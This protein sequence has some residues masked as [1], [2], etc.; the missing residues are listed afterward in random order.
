MINPYHH[1]ILE[2]IKESSG[3][4]T[5][6]TLLDTYL[7]NSHPR[8]PITAPVLRTIAK[9][10]MREH[11]DLPKGDFRAMLTSLINGVSSTEKSNGRDTHGLC[12]AIPGQFSPENF[13]FMA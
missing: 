3:K 9:S 13:Q 8:Y 1:D 4:G 5:Q 12:Y 2:M 11:R 10:W 6:H 7:G